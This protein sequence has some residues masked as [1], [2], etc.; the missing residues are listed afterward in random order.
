MASP[1]PFPPEIIPEIVF[2]LTH[3]FCDLSSVHD[4]E[5]RGEW[6]RVDSGIQ[7]ATVNRV[8]QDAVERGNFARLHLNRA[9]LAEVDAIL[10]QVPR[11][12]KYVR[13]IYLD[14]PLPQA[15]PDDDRKQH[16]RVAQQMFETFL[17][18]LKHWT[19]GPPVEF[20]L[21]CGV[22]Q[23]P[24]PLELEDPQRILSCPE[25]NAIT[26][27]SG[28]AIS[29]ATM[30]T[31]LS[32]LPAVRIVDMGCW[33]EGDW[34]P[35]R[36]EFA[37]ALTNITHALDY[38]HIEGDSPGNRLQQYS[39]QPTQFEKR[40]D[41]LS[42]ALGVLSQRVRHFEIGGFALSDDLFLEH[43][44]TPSSLTVTK[45]TAAHWTRLETF[46]IIYTS[47]TPSGVRWFHPHPSDPEWEVTSRTLQQ[48]YLTVARAALEMPRLQ[49][50]KLMVLTR[51]KGWHKFWYCSGA[52]MSMGT[53][54]VLWT[55]NPVF[56]PDDEVRAAWCEV[57][58]RYQPGKELEIEILQ[59]E[60]PTGTLFEAEFERTL[61]NWWDY[62]TI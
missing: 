60:Y 55:S 39:Q 53:P 1:G 44:V 56:V 33:I 54:K 5:P 6:L 36:R 8:W 29:G 41:E 62:A 32:R 27:F 30:C 18:T 11:R 52:G 23:L 43:N 50:M 10:N 25:V 12:Q 49:Q 26:S 9:R 28:Y 57:A 40:P 34:C 58:Q 22:G 24:K 31:L 14:V 17:S 59:D 61:P 48:Y 7:Y 19:P 15:L 46:C 35:A 38:F 16:S 45:I 3:A 2:F 42:L 20:V 47:V 4:P 51:D 37:Q 13:S 21:R